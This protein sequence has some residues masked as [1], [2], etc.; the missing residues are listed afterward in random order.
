MAGVAVFA[1]FMS[2]SEDEELNFDPRKSNDTY[3]FF[4]TAQ[5]PIPI[6]FL[7]K[8]LLR[9]RKS[10]RICFLVCCSS[11][12]QVG[13]AENVD[14]NGHPKTNEPSEKHE[15]HEDEENGKENTAE[16]LDHN[17]IHIS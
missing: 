4:I 8:S 14:M 3:Y 16:T 17:K 1:S 9:S 5:T 11:G 13:S 2:F 6:F 15:D 7:F 12:D 10:K